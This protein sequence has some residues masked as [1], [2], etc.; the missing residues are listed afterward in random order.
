MRA[1]QYMLMVVGFLMT[2][3][4]AM[5]QGQTVGLFVNQDE[6]FEG[7]TLLAPLFHNT[8]YLIN[9]DGEVVHK[10]THA[11]RPAGATYL[12]PDGNLFR[13]SL[14]INPALNFGGLGGT[15]QEV[16]WEGNIVWEFVY[17]DSLHALHHDTARLPNTQIPRGKPWVSS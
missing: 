7:Y 12:L 14:T 5:A 2:A 3:G 8:T 15:I 13:G 11:L 17:S 1:I 9:N 10:W 6:A 4:G 16:D